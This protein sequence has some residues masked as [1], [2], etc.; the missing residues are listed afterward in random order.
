MF[1]FWRAAALIPAL[2]LISHCLA[3][4]QANTANLEGTI[5]DQTGAVVPGVTVTATNKATSLS[6]TGVTN[7]AG[8]YR[9]PLLPSGTYEL[10]AELAGFRAEVRQGVTLTVGQFASLDFTMTVSATPTEIV[11]EENALILEPSKTQLSETI[12]QVQIDNLPINGRNYLD[13]TL[14][15]PGVTN[16]N[17]LVRFSAVQVPTSG[18]SFNGQNGR[19]NN[20]TIDGVNSVDSVSN[21][22]LAI[23]S[24]EGISEFQ[25]N[26]NSFSAEFG[27]AQG[28]VINIVT[29]SGTNEF[30]GN[31]FYF[32]RDQAVDAR[33]AFATGPLEPA[34]RRRQYGGT[35]GGPIVR[36]KA[37]FFASFERLVRNESIFVTF[38]NDSSIFGLTPAQKQLFD[39]LAQAPVTSLRQLAAALANPQV[40]ILNTTDRTFPNTLALFKRESGT[41]PFEANQNTF[42][43]KNDLHLS[44]ANQ[45]FTR[46]SITRGF[47][48]NTE[49]GALKGVS[50]GVSFHTNDY[51]LVVSDTHIIDPRRLNEFKFEYARR[52]NR[53]LTNDPV[54]PQITLAG[55]AD[56][57]REFFNPTRYISN[58]FEFIDNFTFIT[59]PHALKFGADYNYT[60]F[61]GAAEVFLG[62][63]FFFSG[64]SI[65]LALLLN[66]FGGPTAAGDV[67]SALAQLGRPDLIPNLQAPTSAVQS[68]NFGLP[69]SFFQG[70]GDPNTEFPYHQLGMYAQDSWKLRPNLTLNVGLR[71]DVEL[72]PKTSNVINATSPFQFDFR[73]VNDKNNFAPRL[74]FSWD[75]RGS[76]KT[77][78][79]GGYGIYYSSFYNAI[80]FVGQ[81][82]SGQISQV[83]VPLTG[84]PGT[85][86]TSA[87][88]F[89][90]FSRNGPLTADR[91]RV[92]GLPPGRTPSIILPQADNM[93]TPY[94][95]QAS[96]GI[97]RELLP[98]LAVAIGY[99]LNRGL[100]LIRSR[101]INVRQIGP[102]KFTL[103]GLDPRSVQIN[104]IETT[105]R[106]IYHGLTISGRKRFSHNHAYQ[107]SYSYGKAIDDATDFI[108]PLQANNQHDLRSERSL[109]AFD[110]RHRLVVSAVL[111]S[112]MESDNRFAKNFFSDWT[113][114]PIFTYAGG[115]PF[116]LLVGFDANGDTH[117][118]TDRPSLPNGQIAGRNTGRGPN[119]VSVDLRLARKINLQPDGKM[120]V[121]VIAEAFNLFNRVNFSGVNN[122][123]GFSLSDFDAKGKRGSPTAPL[124]FTSAYDPRQIQFG[125]KVNF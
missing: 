82:L 125:L 38:L 5:K 84:L 40:G 7:D 79:R 61:R 33:N 93:K 101:D 122:V 27:R 51:A 57:G 90:D 86:A 119:F 96:L 24:Q 31:T 67:A 99:N 92:L 50:N 71:Y 41:F 11:V 97:E 17:P 58:L 113:L 63:R 21:S 42:S 29:K 25:I 48:D 105:G 91:L 109:S 85:A 28:G 34:F 55:V 73:S 88:V 75:P 117:D 80:A 56:F 62:G 39:F 69:V 121:E 110:E 64:S 60:R 107:I 87:T 95:H 116:N 15:T 26:R 102:N 46:L 78:I 100:H 104:Q 120:N 4:S 72:R 35:F 66:N 94:S 9:I 59:G 44:E 20:V 65:P 8:L 76:G 18:L 111:V 49:F 54:G 81:V 12:N 1:R 53:V 77:A 2:F 10:R 68:F 108:T 6:R 106:S 74:G 89:A 19:G 45:L 52:N 3:Q 112:K 124:G 123:V 23:L 115:K 22:S 14:L 70:F 13:F 47:N 83:F 36:D 114:S 43:L 37:F 118:E 30:H 32:I 103:P 16:R 98:D